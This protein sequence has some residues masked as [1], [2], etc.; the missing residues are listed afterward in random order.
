MKKVLAFG[1]CVLSLALVCAPASATV[2]RFDDITTE[3]EAGITDGY[4]GFDWHNFWVLDATHFASNPSGYLNGLVSPDYV[5]FNAWGE[6]AEFSGAA[7]NFTGAYLTSA[8]RDG[9]NVQIEGYRLGTLI[10]SDVVVVNTSGPLWFQADYLNVD[11]IRFVSSGGTHH[12]GVHGDGTQFALD[13]LTT[14]AIP[15]PG[16]ILLVGIGTTLTGWL[17]RRRMM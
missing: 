13:N 16:A 7:F 4:A 6:P 14:V 3:P 17:R 15:A 8:W 10:Y 11:T 2:D 1:I 9:L 12:Y 5:A